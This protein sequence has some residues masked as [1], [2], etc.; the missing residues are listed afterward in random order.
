[1]NIRESLGFKLVKIL[2]LKRCLTDL[3]MKKFGLSRTQWRVLL[4]MKI[5]GPC[6]QK[7][8]LTNLEIDPGHLARVLDEFEKNKYIVRTPLK[9]D[10]RALHIETTKLCHQKLMPHLQKTLEEENAILID[11]LTVNEKNAL[12]STLEKI[13]KNM[14]KILKTKSAGE[15][16]EK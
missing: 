1:M 4:W 15:P 6:S 2:K 16:D 10:R 5:L 13:E 7:E 12:L 9:S 3:K 11:G 14:E 8:L